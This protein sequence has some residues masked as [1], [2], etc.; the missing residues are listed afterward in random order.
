MWLG[1]EQRKCQQHHQADDIGYGEDHQEFSCFGAG[2]AHVELQWDKACQGCDKC[3]RSADIYA[4]K[5]IGI[6]FGKKRIMPVIEKT[7]SE[8]LKRFF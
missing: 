7:N 3:A 6:V 2:V 5:K 1:S 4:D 8:L